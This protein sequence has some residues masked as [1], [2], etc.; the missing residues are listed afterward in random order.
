VKAINIYLNS[1][2]K[3]IDTN[4]PH[5]QPR[6][7]NIVVQNNYPVVEIKTVQQ[8]LDLL[9][10]RLF[11]TSLCVCDCPVCTFSFCKSANWPAVKQC[12]H[13]MSSQYFVKNF[14]ERKDA[15]VFRLRSINYPFTQVKSRV[16]LS[17]LIA[18][19]S[20]FLTML[21]HTKCACC[22]GRDHFIPSNPSISV[23]I[24]IYLRPPD[25]VL[26]DR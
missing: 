14:D 6:R 21:Q 1:L 8:K 20:L 7:F 23:L 9:L 11:I 13:I 10:Q 17:I 12:V 19:L 3:K 5:E 18:K 16:P 2:G 26:Y 15:R 24:T 22:F 25:I 4:F